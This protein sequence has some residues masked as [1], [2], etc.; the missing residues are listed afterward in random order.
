MDF[1]RFLASFICGLTLPLAAMGQTAEQERFIKANILAVF[2]HELG[3]AVIDVEDLPIYGQEE[4]AADVFSI[5]MI[6]ALFEEELARD[7]AFDTAQGFR[8]EKAFD[9]QT[10]AEDNWSGVHGLSEQ[11]FYNSVCIFYGANRAMRRG[12]ADE[13]GL[14]EARAE[15]CVEEYAQANHSWGAVLDDLIARGAGKSL[16]FDGQG[17]GSR[18]AELLAHEVAYLNSVLQLAAPI[19]VVVEP[20]DDANAYYYTSE[21]L[22]QFCEEFE[23]YFEDM[24]RWLL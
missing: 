2:Y 9:A 20:C 15:T 13:L 10:D 7:V 16:R 4:D 18:A 24:A 6:D 21:R 19:T 23:I 11:R 12:F 1:I 14:P 22:I 5:F 8:A 3:H 17:L